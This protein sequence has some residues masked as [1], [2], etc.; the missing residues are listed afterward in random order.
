[1]AP[2]PMSAAEAAELLSVAVG[3]RFQVV[4][5]L[6]GGETG[7]TAVEDADGRRSV[8]KWELDADNR[9]RRREGAVLAERLRLDAGWPAP[10]QQLVE[11]DGCLL[12]TQQFMFDQGIRALP[13]APRNAYVGNLLLRFLDWPIRK[14]RTAEIEFW[15]VQAERLLFG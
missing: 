9:A 11:V 3:G 10:E 7:A 13:D 5:P 12:I 2:R 1:V 6:A 8:L 14:Q 4:G 15:T